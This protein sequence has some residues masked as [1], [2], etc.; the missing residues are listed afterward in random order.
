M[1]SVASP[2][3]DPILASCWDDHERGWARVA[4][5]WLQDEW[6]RE[7]NDDSP[8][9]LKRF[10]RTI[11]EMGVSARVAEQIIHRHWNL[12]GTAPPPWTVEQIHEAAEA[13]NREWRGEVQTE[14][15]KLLDVSEPLP[16]LE[17]LVDGL[18]VKN[19]VVLLAAYGGSLKTWVALSLMLAIQSGKPWLGRYQVRQGNVMLL[20]YES[21]E[22]EVRRR[23]RLLAKGESVPPIR[24][25]WVG[26]SLH[27]EQTWRQIERDVVR[28][29][30]RLLVIDSLAGGSGVENENDAAFALPLKFAARLAEEY[31]C[32]VWFIHH[33]RKGDG[34]GPERIRGSSAI[35]GAVDAAWR[36]SQMKDDGEFK[37]TT[38][39]PTKPGAGPT[40]TPIHLKLSDQGGL[41]IDVAVPAASD[42]ET[43]EAILALVRRKA[44][45]GG[46]TAR[47]LRDAVPGRGTKKD[48]A[49]KELEKD[50]LIVKIGD[51]YMPDGDAQRLAR[52]E[53]IIRQGYSTRRDITRLAKI[54]GDRLDDLVR[55]QRVIYDGHAYAIGDAPAGTAHAT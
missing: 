38:F 27:D 2:E 17:Y 31:G 30:I 35:H 33:E 32:S 34:T 20:D 4:I 42:E 22:Y 1:N 48:G 55:Q 26:G 45:S 13:A 23:L 36:C 51:R 12:V 47:D 49:R 29:N 6:G 8:E 53:A 28:F 44:G 41:Q 25:T 14:Y 9:T 19:D 52:V 3:D 40:P 46:A 54:T 7:Q 15:S 21:G 50:G 43:R 37:R 39:E 18:F 5:S 11:V 16:T 24:Y 10:A